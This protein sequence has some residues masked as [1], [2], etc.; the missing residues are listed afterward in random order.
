LAN[1]ST[2]SYGWSEKGTQPRIEQQQ[3]KRERC[4]LF[5]C[6]NPKSGEVYTHKSKRGNTL[7]FFRFLLI[8]IL[9]NPN[10]KIYMILDNVRYHHAKRLA[11]ILERYK[12]RIEL[13]FLPAY[14]PD[15]NSMERVWWYMRKKIT[16]N[17]GIKTLE[18][19][20]QDFDKLFNEF[21]IPNEIG[22]NLCN[23]VVNI[24]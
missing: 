10:K 5:G 1:T 3:S 12:H 15:L 14:S 16:H 21:K 6:V 24:Y 7:E 23:L 19:R 2:V 22:K 4:T 13:I 9:S 8:V 11:P 17:R 18:E 20:K